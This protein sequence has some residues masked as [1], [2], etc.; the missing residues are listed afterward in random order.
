MRYAVMLVAVTLVLLLSA[1]SSQLGYRFADTLVEWKLDDYVELNEQQE[2]RVDTAITSLHYWHATSELPFYAEQLQQ[3][4]DQVADKQLDEASLIAVY[5]QVFVA[6]QRM[7]SGLRPYALELLPELS[8]AQVT[9]LMQKL[10]ERQQEERDELA[11]YD[12]SEL[13]QRTRKRAEK[14]ARSW[15]GQL[16]PLQERLIRSWVSERLPTRAL[17][18]DYNEKWQSSFQETLMIRQD[19][20]RFA[21]QLDRLMFEP[22][23]LRSEQLKAGIQTNQDATLSLILKLEQSLTDRQRRRVL[24]KLDGYIEDMQ[25][26]NEH[27]R[28]QGPEN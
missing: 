13:V 15:L 8:D 12:D 1:C 4:R 25:E 10:N 24:A 6:W 27:F 19:T 11:E 2:Q 5:E 23:Q 16:T 21:A 18:L 14:N 3:L 17:W 28:Q 9:Q 7:L 26:L 20:E 22:Q